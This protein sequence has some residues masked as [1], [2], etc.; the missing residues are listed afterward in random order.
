MPVFFLSNGISAPAACEAR[1][2]RVF[3]TQRARRLLRPLL[4]GCV[5]L[6]PFSYLV[7]G[8]G[9]MVTGQIHLDDILRWRF[10]PEVSHHLYGL[11]HFWFLEYLF[12]VCLFWAGGWSLR[13][14]ILGRLAPVLTNRAEQQAEKPRFIDRALESP[15]RPA[16][17]ALPTL[18]IFLIDSDTMLRVDNAIIPNAFRLLHYAYFFTV[19]GWISRTR[20]PKARFIPY[21]TL[22]L[23]LSFLLFAAMSPL[24]LHHAATPLTGSARLVY[25]VFAAL[26]PWL[27][28][29]GALGVFLRVLQGRGAIMRYLAE[30][31]FWVYMAHLPLIALAQVVLLP[32]P[33]PAPVKFVLVATFATSL[34]LASY[35]AIV[36]R[37]LIGELINGARKRSASKGWLGLGPEFGWIAT[38]AAA[39][40]IIAGGA[41]YSRVFFWGYNLYEEV[42]GRL[43]R[44]APARRGPGRRDPPQS[45]PNGDH[46][47]RRHRPTRLVR[48]P[49]EGVR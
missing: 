41:W 19:G 33:W 29:F 12:L 49:E 30:S 48:G 45:Y 27:T 24:L 36:R 42:P 39:A 15:W 34:S 2:T 22:Y 14:L 47:F 20:D 37:S 38:L 3:I 26:F 28:V 31:S 18:A 43:Y 7:W 16:L 25:C 1:G 4:V 35:E 44:A 9:L 13:S 17:L 11:G 21:S 46:L 8:Y 32:L 23:T 10:G 40:L 6:L 5:T